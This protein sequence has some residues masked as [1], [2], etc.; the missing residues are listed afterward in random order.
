[1]AALSVVCAF[2][3]RPMPRRARA[4]ELVADVT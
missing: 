3:I 2:F 1:M 4:V